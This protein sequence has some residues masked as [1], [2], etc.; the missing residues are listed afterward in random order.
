MAAGKPIVA[1]RAA[2]IPEIVPHGTLV[3]PDDAEALAAAIAALYE[4]PAQRAL[5]AAA[6]QQWVE[7]FDAPRVARIF[8]DA[9]APLISY[10]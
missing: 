1:S 2:A 4:S 5:L 7:Q 6:G 9:V 8:L 10:L 3:E